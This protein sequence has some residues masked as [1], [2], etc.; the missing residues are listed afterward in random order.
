M[1]LR[2]TSL[3]EQFVALFGPRA[4]VVAIARWK[5]HGSVCGCPPI[6][7]QLCGW[8]TE[9][10]AAMI[11]SLEALDRGRYTGAVGWVDARG[12]G[13][14][15]VALRSATLDGPLA[16]LAAGAGIVA[17]S[18]PEAEWRETEAK[19]APMLAALG[20]TQG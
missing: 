1:L 8:P 10:A 14:W 13:D 18:D 2:D 5:V 6:M 11:E 17:G 15:A 20:V 7:L 16:R 4:I 19:L 9:S 12:D 3:R